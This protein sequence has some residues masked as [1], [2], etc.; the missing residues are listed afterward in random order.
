MQIRLH[1]CYNSPIIDSTENFFKKKKRKTN[2]SEIKGKIQALRVDPK[3]K[4]NQGED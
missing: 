3:S 2:Q 4:K 1:P